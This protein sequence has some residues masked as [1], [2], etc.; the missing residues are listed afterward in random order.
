MH[1]SK[2]NNAKYTRKEGGERLSPNLSVCQAI[3]HAIRTPSNHPELPIWP[4]E[5]EQNRKGATAFFAV[6]SGTGGNVRER[7]E[8]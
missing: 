2:N 3:H 4:T 8:Q 7:A 6:E 5:A 1:K